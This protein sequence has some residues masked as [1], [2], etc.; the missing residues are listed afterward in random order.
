MKFIYPYQEGLVKLL[1]LVAIGGFL[2]LPFFSQAVTVGPT[3]LE[4][5]A[6]PGDTL[7]GTTFLM[8]ESKTTKTYYPS[9]EGFTEENGT[10][11]FFPEKVDLASW[12][13]IP[14]KVTLKP[15]EQKTIPYI[16]HIPKDAAPGGHFAV[17]W[18]S[19]RAP[20]GGQNVSIAARAGILVYLRVSGKVTEE[21]TVSFSTAKGH[22]VFRLPLSFSILFKNKGNVYLKPRGTIKVKNIFGGTRALIEVNKKDFSILPHSQKVLEAKWEQG[23]FLLGPYKANLNLNYGESNKKVAKSL[24]IVILPWKTLSWLGFILLLIFWAIPQGLKKYNRR[25]VEKYQ[26]AKENSSK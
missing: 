26:S 16:L 1:L 8:N 12:F 9:F 25:I 3:K 2:L 4:I 24:W 10:K 13:E 17:M 5:N 21:G 11:K 6:N 20:T 14:Q 7:R 19:T 18:W 23:G 22:L 15:Q